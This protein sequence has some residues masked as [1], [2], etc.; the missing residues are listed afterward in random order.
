MDDHGKL[1]KETAVALVKKYT[2]LSGFLL[3]IAKGIIDICANIKVDANPCEAA[4]Q[5]G[6][7]FKKELN[8]R[9]IK[10]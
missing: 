2:G 8:A 1:V 3:N 4:I 6:K 10:F 5:Y 9:Y 7:C